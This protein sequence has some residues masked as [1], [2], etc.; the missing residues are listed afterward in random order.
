MFENIKIHKNIKTKE[1]KFFK[2]YFAN[3]QVEGVHKSTP[4]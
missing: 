3:T 2:A 1:I 4:N